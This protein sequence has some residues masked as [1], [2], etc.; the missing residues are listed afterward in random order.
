MEGLLSLFAED[1]DQETTTPTTL[2]ALS[3]DKN[4]L[5][6]HR[7]R[8]RMIQ[9]L[10]EASPNLHK[11]DL[12]DDDQGSRREKN[13]LKAT[14]RGLQSPSCAVQTLK[15]G[16]ME[17]ALRQS[18]IKAIPTFRVTSFSFNEQHI[19]DRQ[20]WDQRDKK[21]LIKAYRSNTCIVEATIPTYA[22]D[23]SDHEQLQIYLERNR[24][25]APTIRAQALEMA[26]R[27][28]NGEDDYGGHGGG[29][30]PHGYCRVSWSWLHDRIPV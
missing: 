19:H 29:D 5:C 30:S 6:R 23:A 22:L 8:P 11:L 25:L 7:I 13:L 15:L 18:M 10:V 27:D 9:N 4:M 24:Q 17:H 1:D 12:W 14:Y 26:T 21:K 20:P 28:D 2:R 3:L 16:D